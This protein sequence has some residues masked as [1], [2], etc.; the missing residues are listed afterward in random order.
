MTPALKP[1]TV[2]CLIA[3]KLASQP[4]KL[5]AE[6]VAAYKD[7]VSDAYS[8]CDAARLDPDYHPLPTGSGYNVYISQKPTASR[9]ISAA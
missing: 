2:G 7:L 5:Y 8:T 1:N 4:A 3:V 9:F 6:L